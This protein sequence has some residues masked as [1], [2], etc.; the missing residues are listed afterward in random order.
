MIKSQIC[1]NYCSKVPLRV[2]KI[3]G[4]ISTI[5]SL[6]FHCFIVVPNFLY[7]NFNE[8]S[9]SLEFSICFSKHFVKYFPK[10]KNNISKNAF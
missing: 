9:V 4:P 3:E 1:P 8:H 5:C 6:H 10:L 2:V 7:R